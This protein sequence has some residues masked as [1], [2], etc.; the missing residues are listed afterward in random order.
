MS[1]PGTYLFGRKPEKEEKP[2]P[3]PLVEEATRK[4]RLSD[5]GGYLFS[6]Q[7]RGPVTAP[8]RAA[9]EQ[10]PRKTADA[11][12]YLFSDLGAKEKPKVEATTAIAPVA[13]GDRAWYSYLTTP[14]WKIVRPESSSLADVY[15]SGIRN[16]RAVL[17]SSLTTG[18]PGWM[19]RFTEEFLKLGP[20]IADFVASPAGLGLLAM[21]FIPFPP[22]QMAALGADVALG[23]KSAIEFVPE[24]AQAYKTGKPEDA[25]TAIKSLVSAFGMRSAGK[26]VAKSMHKGGA[27]L[28]M[29]QEQALARIQEL[30]EMP[31][32]ERTDAFIGMGIPRTRMETALRWIQTKAGLGAFSRVVFDLPKPRLLEYGQHLVDA[33]DAF[34]NVNDAQTAM[35]TNT[36]RKFAT[37][38]ERVIERMGYAMQKSITPEEARLSESAKQAI[39]INRKEQA[40]FDKQIREVYGEHVGLQDPERYLAQ[41][42][43]LSREGMK[44]I[45]AVSRNIVRD[46]FLREKLIDDYKYGKE[47]AG[48]TPRFNDVA[49]IIE[50]RRQYATRAM[51]NRMFA[52]ALKKMGAMVD[53]R[54]MHQ[55][56]LYSYVQ[57]VNTPA[58]QKATY[59]GK[60]PKG[61]RTLMM[62]NQYIHP[63]I[64]PAINAIFGEPWGKTIPGTEYRSLFGA[65]ELLRAFQKQQAV[66]WSFFH[67]IALG[68][69]S[70]GVYASLAT[71]NP[72]YIGKWFTSMFFLNP[73]FYKG[74][75]SGIYETVGHKYG[76]KRPSDPPY[77]TRKREEILDPLQH[78]MSLRTAEQETTVVRTLRHAFDRSDSRLARAAGIPFRTIGN[79]AYIFNRAL[80]D[81]YLP[82]SMLDSYWSI[83]RQELAKNIDRS[84][85]EISQLKRTIADHL[86]RIYGAEN[87]ERLLLHPK[88]RQAMAFLFFAPIWTLSNIRNVTA[89]YQNEAGARLTNRWIAGAAFSWFLTSQ[90]ANYA[91]SKQFDMPDREGKT[92]G[93]WMWD[94]P[95]APLYFNGKYYEGL[96]DNAVNIAD[97]YNLDGSERYI[98]FGKAFREP[99]MWML[100]PLK[101]LGT[102]LSIPIQLAMTTIT[103]HE[104]GTGF[105]VI[106]KEADPATQRK[107]FAG[108]ILE[109][110]MPFGMQDVYRKGMRAIAPETIPES[111]LRQQYLELFGTPVMPSG[112]TVRKGLSYTTAVQSY[113]EAILEGREDKMRE[114]I[115]A[116]VFNYIRHRDKAGNYD[117]DRIVSN[118]VREAHKQLR[119]QEEIK[120]GHPFR[121]DDY[122]QP[123]EPGESE[124]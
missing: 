44:K 17:P 26:L 13:R 27:P 41:V 10:A 23:L 121:Y 124:R 36:I 30:S 91:R 84:P 87:L 53:E 120:Y 71:R 79:V 48:L 92:G 9:R 123:I 103:G 46:K 33:R 110:F 12:K 73:D 108:M 106:E 88:A 4:P 7:G 28:R 15:E 31:L 11:S 97:G 25:A 112:L 115:D 50:Y 39:E 54:Q 61:E 42:W 16:V 70:Q 80:W 75:K 99:F 45:R 96:T 51:A 94:N 21:H 29:T 83:L 74:I 77:L 72:K 105:K 8:E 81:Y 56:R 65:V 38:E 24:T 109:S 1:S 3:D 98:R 63:D 6:R 113:K 64:A 20:E 55:L 118:V 82:G 19:E 114:V 57:A 32:K 34:I 58:L 104:P 47:E 52:D 49:D 37:P 90:L 78:N 40:E 18:T 69:V 86:N 85:A 35:L 116:V 60:T 89:G 5:T 119:K 43:D 95:G 111:N 102:K 59:I 117:V 22:T 100:E 66:M 101:T 76:M 107:Q 122:G 93:H 62:R 68:E 67:N 2:K 14:S